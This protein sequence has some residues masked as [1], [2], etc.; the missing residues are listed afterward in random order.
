MKR[1]SAANCTRMGI[2]MLA[3]GVRW[4]LP[5]NT[6]AVAARRQSTPPHS[7]Q[8][9]ILHPRRSKH[10]LV[11]PIRDRAIC[12]RDLI[13]AGDGHVSRGGSDSQI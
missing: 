5:L 11:S 2:R 9:G 3:C 7:P 10:V 12:E 4:Y 8:L 1:T 6:C 13:A